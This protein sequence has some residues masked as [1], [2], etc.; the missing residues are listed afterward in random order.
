[1]NNE[2]DPQAADAAAMVAQVRAAMIEKGIN[3]SEL[4]RRSGFTRSYISRLFSEGPDR[5]EATLS[6]ALLLAHTVGL[7]RFVE[8]DAR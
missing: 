1:M 6:T 7:I 8:E 3:Q 5:R 2:R 4:A